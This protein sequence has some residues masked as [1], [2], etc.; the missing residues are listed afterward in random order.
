M[1]WIADRI[2]G[3]V[4]CGL[5]LLCF[6][7]SR[8]VWSGWDGPG[9]MPLIVGIVLLSLA[10]GFWLFP[11]KDLTDF[12][13]IETRMLGHIGIT[14]ASFA[15]YIAFMRW[16]GYPLATW[17]LLFTVARSMKRSPIYRTLIWS[18]MV[19]IGSY[20]VFKIYLA[21][22]LPSGFMGI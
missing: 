5:S 9:T 14:L 11:T 12:R 4:M 1:R 16:L 2:L 21:M 18:G 15:L 13:S 8:Q 10:L 19:S 17:L 3:G 22:S 7:V 20:I 6:I